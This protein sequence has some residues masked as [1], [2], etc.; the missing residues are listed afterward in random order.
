MYSATDMLR[1]QM[2]AY[3]E[4][5]RLEQDHVIGGW[6]LE[7]WLETGLSIFRLIRT[8]DERVG[9]VAPEVGELYA[10]WLGAAAGPLGRLNQMGAQAERVADATEFRESERE[11]RGALRVPLGA[12]L[13]P[14]DSSRVS[15]VVVP[16]IADAGGSSVHA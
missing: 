11:A 14:S 7:T 9:S 16:E 2:H 10:E 1:R 13:A 6:E 12:V 15:D 4:A 8:L 5:W 3:S